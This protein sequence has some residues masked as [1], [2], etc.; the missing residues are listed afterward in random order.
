MP[1]LI[2]NPYAASETPSNTDKL[3]TV[4][5]AKEDKLRNLRDVTY[6]KVTLQSLYDV[7]SPRFE[8]VTGGVGGTAKDGTVYDR[9]GQYTADRIKGIDSFEVFPSSEETLLY[10][11]QN[12]D[13]IKKMAKQRNALAATLG[14]DPSTVTNEDVY[15]RG[16]RDALKTLAIAEAYS[17]G[18]G[19]DYIQ[20]VID[21]EPSKELTAQWRTSAPKFGSAENLKNLNVQ[22]E[23]AFLNEYG[24]YG[25]PLTQVRPLGSKYLLGEEGVGYEYYKDKDKAPRPQVT[26]D[27]VREG[28]LRSQAEN[29]GVTDRLGN[30]ID[31][32][33]STLAKEVVVDFADWVGESLNKV[34]GGKVGWDIGTEE[35]KDN[36]VNKTFGFNPY[37]S[38]KELEQAKQY[39]TNIVN[40]VVDEN[41]DIDFNDA[42]ELIKIG[43]TTPEL[44]GQ[45]A[46][47]IGS[48]FVP[49]LGWGGKAAKADKIVSGANSV[50]KATEKAL[51]AGEITKDAAKATVIAQ[52]AKIAEATADVNIINKLTSFTQQNAGLMQVAAGNVNDQIDRYK[53]EQGSDP[54]PGKVAQM[55]ATE[56][57]MLSLDRWVDLSI[58]KAPSALKGTRDAFTA[59]AKEG[60]TKVLAKLVGNTFG[61]AANM[62]KE[63]A[64]EYI[65]EIGQEFNVKFN[66]DDNTGEFLSA[67]TLDEAKEVFL[68]KDMQ[69]VGVTGAGLGAGGAVQFATVGAIPKILGTSV[70]EVSKAGGKLGEVI[71]KKK[72]PKEAEVEEVSLSPEELKT[73]N[74]EADKKANQ[75]AFKYA[76]MFGEEESL[77]LDQTADL[78]EQK[79]V[80]TPEL[81]A[82]LKSSGKSFADIIEEIEAAE[83]VI[84]GRQNTDRQKDSDELAMRMLR[85]A[86]LQAAKK[87]MESK[88]PSV[89]G[90]GFSPE[91]VVDTYIDAATNSE[92]VVEIT[93]EDKTLVNNFLKKNGQKPYRFGL[94]AAKMEG[95]DAAAVYQD[96][97]G[98]GSNSA[99][100]R[101]ARLRQLLNT[102][103]ASKALIQKEVD[104]IRN[105]L[106]TQLD[107]KQEYETARAQL[108]ADIDTYNNAKGA[109]KAVPPKGINFG[110][111][112]F[113]N[114]E[115]GPDGKYRIETKS[116]AL[117]DSL[118][119]TI[120]HL[121][122]TL[123][124]YSKA[125][126][127]ALGVTTNENFVDVPASTRVSKGAQEAREKDKKFYDE[128]KL[129]KVI[130]DEKSSPEQWKSGKDYFT[131]N[132]SKLAKFSTEFTPEDVV[133]LTTLNI[134]PGSETS[135]T[136]SKAIQAGATIVVDRQLQTKENTV[137]IRNLA[138]RY[139]AGAVTVDGKAVW[140]PRK[141]AVEVMTQSR[142]E[143]NARKVKEKKLNNLT[144]AFDA[145]WNSNGK[146]TKQVADNL[147]K[148]I[149]EAKEYFGGDKSLENMRAYA[150]NALTKEAVELQKDLETIML[151][152]G[153]SSKAYS[154][155]IG[156]AT[157]TAARIA[158]K[159]VKAKE[160]RLAKGGT[161]VAEW[162][163]AEAEAKK[164]GTPLDQWIKNTFGND[165][166]AIAVKMINDSL[167]KAKTPEKVIYSYKKKGKADYATTTNLKDVENLSEDG[168][169]HIIEVNPETY[170]QVAKA[171]LLNTLNVEELKLAGEVNVLFNQF[172]EES[173]G[174]LKSTLGEIDLD[175]KILPYD[176]ID[177]P[178]ASLIF[179]KDEKLNANFAVAARVALYNFVRNNG[180]LLSK[181]FKSEKD[182]A[183][184][185]GKHESEL[186]DAAIIAMQDKGLLMKTAADSVGK[187]IMKLLGLQAKNTPTVD[188]QAF[189]ALTTEFG[190]I[191]LA[192]GM[193]KSE[194]MLSMSSMPSAKFATDVLGKKSIDVTSSD[195][196]VNFIEIKDQSKVDEAMLVVETLNN[197]LPGLDVRRKEPSFTKL[198][199]E[200][201][202]EASKKIKK[203]KLGL[204]VASESKKAMDALMDTEVVADMPLL[205]FA[206]DPKNKMR[207]MKLLGWVELD[208]DEFKK[209]SYKEQ[210]T[211]ASKNLDIERNFGH[212]EWLNTQTDP[213]TTKVSMWF[214]YFFSKNGRFFVDSN[215]LNPQTN[216]HLDRFFM[217]P[218]EHNN[219]YTKEGNV[220]KVNG[221][222]VTFLV[223]YALAQAF[224]FATDKKANSSIT[225]FSTKILTQ[226]NT[227]AKLNEARETF[228]N[229][230]KVESL[231]IKIEHL[232]HALQAFD[233]LDKMLTNPSKFESPITAEF[234]AVTSGF[235]LKLLQM[236]IIGE[237]LYD[238]LGKVGIVKK[239]DENINKVEGEGLSMNNLLNLDDFLDS[240]QFLASSIKP[241]S[242]ATLQSNSDSRL[243]QADEGYA[244]NLWEAVSKVLP[245]VDPE[246]GIS[247]DLRS[248]FKYPFMT[249][250]YASSIKSIRSRLKGTMQDDI[251]KQIAALDLSKQEQKPEAQNI[252]NMLKVFAE[253]ED[254]KVLEDLQKQVREKQLS[255][256]KVG[257][258]YSL[259]AYLDAMIDASYGIQV[260]EVL[261]KEFTPFVEIQDAVN[262][263]FKAMFAVFK[264][265]FEQE[266]LKA[267]K[268][269]PV[270]AQKE[271]EIYKTLKDKWPAIKG[272]LSAMEEEFSTPG[273]IGVY[274]T[275]TAS[276]YGVYAGRKAAITKLS[277]E[278]KKAL[279]SATIRT[280]HMIKAL[281]AAIS[282]GS[283]IP[284]HYI[285]G[286]V[287]GTT[288]LNMGG[289]ITSIHDAVMPNLL[290]MA[291]AQNSYNKATV[292]VSA[293]YSF[294]DEIVK[295]LDRIIKGTE[296]FTEQSPYQKTKVKV[297]KDEE[298]SVASFIVKTRNTMAAFAN[299]VNASRKEL[300]T[301][302][303][304]GAHVMHMAGTTD[305]VHTIDSNSPIQYT[306][307]DS[308]KEIKDN[309]TTKTV[310]KVSITELDELASNHC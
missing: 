74:A 223:H 95:K 269:G 151:R 32:F 197:T 300:F 85:K 298:T 177:S 113:L 287:M 41:K 231:G 171:T 94:L 27:Q 299:S 258:G 196:T 264:V 211:Q 56:T 200:E 130:V 243:L 141:E 180:Y 228:L 88:E 268:K 148:A 153:T 50:I 109:G 98:Q 99:P 185:L 65:Q 91:D 289:N 251:A 229:E 140:K 244:K 174:N 87:I 5:A 225:A 60:K 220:F 189:T 270:S 146:P 70:S 128:R 232:G 55:L 29:M 134:K 4:A 166:R 195:S 18:R 114:P 292:E 84:D 295:S 76:Q 253:T 210:K 208:S 93:P 77:K 301:E 22:V 83:V 126:S 183:D 129:T 222:D 132:E 145:Q 235:A 90:S 285:D 96:S 181:E 237:K 219:V 165:A 46:G 310:K 154:E 281:S 252:I 120:D 3:S 290:R 20:Q 175:R 101:R 59:L 107:R 48:L 187:D 73:A 104:G 216:K 156:Q 297:A 176:L 280:S 44:F 191:A 36:L 249:F 103:G 188:A 81:D 147:T 218:K 17:S 34:T 272:P 199:E 302:L 238:W 168:I 296:L 79:I 33:Q 247:S 13:G 16:A 24:N 121:E 51:K 8:N 217:Q 266:L 133:L 105:F 89:L 291:E 282:A 69:I 227:K 42:Y 159:E 92:G 10:Q 284:I 182:I 309:S 164:G 212:L 149:E 163:E 198:S 110:E 246:G 38:K 106:N 100:N 52:K 273:G 2:P 11:T 306:A 158:D 240:Y 131:L 160:V 206:I 254:T 43:V 308:Y 242:Y 256:V 150:K 201:K 26:E 31:A 23:R 184:M 307:I 236:P 53:K 7:D 179:D 215:T 161:L 262:N 255:F 138:K 45:S 14:V 173:L 205:R 116:Q 47:F 267:R 275:D 28:Y 112:R 172:V 263:S 117:L 135:K 80:D 1:E 248:L 213:K 162:K 155:R 75:T 58:L 57:L 111:G 283:V 68:A 167:G 303:N 49:F 63:A 276:P 192:M 86:K 265:S 66:F 241:T 277:P 226:L 115:R 230:G 136:L 139:G 61:L 124:R 271:E 125:T 204:D 78:E 169:Y 186:S 207:I 35:Y 178:A 157:K 152:E 127:K 209:L 144:A 288:V 37:A 72:A 102:P 71:T 122:T 9:T 82:A 143:S 25:R 108:Q 233:F 224:G 194:G 304:K 15:E 250:N 245:S 67:E 19:S 257:K 278:M 214:K 261:N 203:E 259:G 119:D 137:R 6:E 190:Q 202:T 12:P 118:D 39:A 123:A 234:D 64:Q 193:D 305:G 293:S 221:K 294:V 21:W 54:S 170:V 142:K 274:S 260:E 279:G 30:A 62:G 40:A 239:T 97:M 286:A